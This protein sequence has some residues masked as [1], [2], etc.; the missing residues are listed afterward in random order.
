M[1]SQKSGIAN[2]KANSKKWTQQYTRSVFLYYAACNPK[3]NVLDFPSYFAQ[4]FGITDNRSYCKKLERQGL[5]KITKRETIDVTQMGQDCIDSEDVAFFRLACPHVT[6][7][8]YRAHRENMED[9]DTFETVMISLMKEKIEELYSA[10]ELQKVCDL[11]IEVALLCERIGDGESAARHYI[12]ALYYDLKGTKYKHI[13][14]AVETGYCT[15]LD[16][17]KQFDS[18]YIRPQIITGLQCVKDCHIDNYVADAL[19]R[20]KLNFCY[21]TPESFPQLVQEILDGTYDELNWREHYLECYKR[22]VRICY[23]QCQKKKKEA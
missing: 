12:K 21:C 15:R 5:T 8:E 17:I 6:I 16:A 23:N 3:V 19:R 1:L 4:E 9:S 22:R 20:K 13:M 18:I 2:A 7:T 14:T 10:R 11:C